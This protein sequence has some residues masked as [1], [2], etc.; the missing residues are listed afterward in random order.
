MEERRLGSA[1]PRLSAVGLGG[2]NF[3]RLGSATHD[4]RGTKAVV[5]AA[6]D[7]GVTLI[8][9]AEAYGS[10]FGLSESLLGGALTSRRDDVVIATKFGLNAKRHALTPDSARGSRTYIRAAVDA[11]LQRLR[12]D[13]IDLYQQHSPDPTTPIEETVTALSELVGEGKIRYFGHS[14]FSPDEIR[15]A[16]EAPGMRSY[17][18]SQNEYSLLNR[19]A[20]KDLI[21]TL[22][23]LGLGLLPYFP[24]ANGLLTGKYTRKDAPAEA[25][26]TARPETLAKAPWDRLDAYAMFCRAHGMTMLEATFA[27]MLA[28]PTVVSVIAGATRPEQVRTNAAAAGRAMT[29]DDLSEVSRIFPVDS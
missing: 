8:D 13:H 21:P 20:E 9:T 5:D 6:I 19:V 22:C 16:A 18:S 17:V 7:A 27:W 4:L 12:T 23:S 10:E 2:N 29:I 26:L 24:L 28:Q 15:L 25:R 1:G 14:N 11:S 3:G